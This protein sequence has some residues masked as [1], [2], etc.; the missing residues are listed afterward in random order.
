MLLRPRVLVTARKTQRPKLQ[1]IREI[2]EI[3]REAAR[4]AHRNLRTN[5][6]DA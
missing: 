3:M 4:M 2:Q 1:D 5:A 6:A